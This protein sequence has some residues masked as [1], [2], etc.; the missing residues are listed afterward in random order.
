M[1]HIEL[2]Y[3]TPF[4]RSLLE[5]SMSAEYAE[6]IVETEGFVERIRDDIETTSAWE[7][8]GYYNLDDVLYAIGRIF[9]EDLNERSLTI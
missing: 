7:T 2:E 1:K 5:R 6:R 3:L 8:E 9:C 4:V